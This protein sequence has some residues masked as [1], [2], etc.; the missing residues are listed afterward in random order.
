MKLFTPILKGLNP[1]APARYS[2]ELK[3]ERGSR[4]LA[5]DLDI[6]ESFKI[7]RITVSP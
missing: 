2:L 4:V 1:E 5:T 6:T 3:T 7:Y